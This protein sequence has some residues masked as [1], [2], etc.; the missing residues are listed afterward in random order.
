MTDSPLARGI[1]ETAFLIDTGPYKGVNEN[2]AG[3]TAS[4]DEDRWE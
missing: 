2:R 4:N 3:R 1:L